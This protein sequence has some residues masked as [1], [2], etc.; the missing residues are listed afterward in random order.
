[1]LAYLVM[2][3][4]AVMVLEEARFAIE[5]LAL[6]LALLVIS[7]IRNAWDL[8]LFFLERRGGE[9]DTPAA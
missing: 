6:A 2:L 8:I 9:G 7:G 5:A 1:L 4:G 3:A